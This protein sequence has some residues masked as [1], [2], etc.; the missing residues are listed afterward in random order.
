MTNTVVNDRS[1]LPESPASQEQF[2]SK[3]EISRHLDPCIQVWR[4]VGPLSPSIHVKP[5]R[6]TWPATRYFCNPRGFRPLVYIADRNSFGRHFSLLR[7]KDRVTSALDVIVEKCFV[8]KMQ[9]AI[10]LSRLSSSVIF[11]N[12]QANGRERVGVVTGK[13]KNTC[14]L[15]LMILCYTSKIWRRRNG[16][17]A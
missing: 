4:F 14:V 5:L 10:C 8:S 17:G 12:V 9:M 3:V 16:G 11:W 6:I 1:S 7:H 2:H 13:T 15:I